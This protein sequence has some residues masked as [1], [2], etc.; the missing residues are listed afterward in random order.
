M[1][2][3]LCVP[4]DDDDEGEHIEFATVHTSAGSSDL[5]TFAKKTAVD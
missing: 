3:V 4:G 2:S 5:T 1:S